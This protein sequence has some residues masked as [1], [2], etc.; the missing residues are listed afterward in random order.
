LDLLTSTDELNKSNV[1][2]SRIIEISSQ[3]KEFES[4]KQKTNDSN[5]LPIYILPPLNTTTATT[6]EQSSSLHIDTFNNPYTYKWDSFPPR[7]S[8]LSTLSS[9]SSYTPKIRNRHFS[10]GSYY[11]NKTTTVAIHPNHT[12]YILA[13][14]PVSPISRTSTTSSESHYYVH[15]HSPISHDNLTYNALRRINPFLETNNYISN[16]E[17]KRAPSL[18]RDDIY[19]TITTYPEEQTMPVRNS[20]KINFYYCLSFIQ[21]TQTEPTS[22]LPQSHPQRS[23]SVPEYEVPTIVPKTSSTSP[24]PLSFTQEPPLVRPKTSRGRPR[25]PPPPPPLP[26]RTASIENDQTQNIYQEIDSTSTDDDQTTAPSADLRFI[27]GTIE[28]V[29]DFHVESTSELSTNYD[30]ITEDNKDD[31]ESISLSN[32]SKKSNQ[33]PA[34]EAVQRFYHNKSPSDSEK[35]NL[36]EQTTNLDENPISNHSS[37]SNKLYARSHPMNIRK[38]EL[39][40]SKSSDIEQATSEEVDDTLNDIEDDD[41]QDEK[42]KRQA[43]NNSSQTSEENSPIHSSDNQIKLK[44][45]SQETQTLHRVCLS[46]DCVVL[47]LFVFSFL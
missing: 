37:T 27:R 6:K 2:Q 1:Y 42:L 11:D 43:T 25:S 38:N 21:I 16:Y 26:P 3:E 32:S 17:Y 9:P 12:F 29:F 45:T 20:F 19:R 5:T 40:E 10:V 47:F 14:A 44:K 33:Y 30:E 23:V 18:N 22:V 4:A 13:S 15:H 24:P 31:N 7:Y 39:S 41:S 35:K 34:V 46:N 28:R 36:I 8:D